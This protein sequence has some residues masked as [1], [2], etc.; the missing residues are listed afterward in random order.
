VL[1]RRSTRRVLG[2]VAGGIA[3]HLQVPVSAVRVI[4][5][6]L[7]FAGGLGAVLYGVFWIVLP[8]PPGTTT[9]SRAV[10]LEYGAAAIVVLVSAIVAVHGTPLGH[11]FLPA[12]LACVGGALIWRQAS[13]S[14][15]ERWWRFSQTS[16]SSRPQVHAGRIRLI[17]GGALVLVGAL[18][19]L[20]RHNLGAVRDSLVGVAVAIVGVAVITGPWWVGMVTEL[21]SERRERIQSQARA[22]LAERVHDS[23]LQT[24]ALIQRNASSPREV[25]RLARGQERELRGLL[26]GTPNVASHLADALRAA[27]AE[28]EDAYGIVV[29]A[30]VVGDAMLDDALN[31]LVAASR[32]ALV[33]AA[34]H[35]G[36]PTVWLYAEVDPN[37]CT[38]F[39]RDRG[40]GFDPDEIGEDRQGLRGSIIGRVERFGG[41]VNVR[42]APGEG[43]EVEIRMGGDQR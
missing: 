10:W 34:K 42:S 32:E 40:R 27:A 41:H 5:V 29:D 28:V 13:E 3:D 39:V 26:Y 24:L 17:L 7:C 12:I 4:F 18:A 43:T 30:V 14:Q 38:A 2:G 21:S 16:L 19:V 23:V 35:A 37:G 11:P 31:A 9:S 25:A 36:T 6:V 8:T 20:D 15:R 22:D 1:Y 33:N